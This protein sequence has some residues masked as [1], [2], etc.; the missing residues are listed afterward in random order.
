MKVMI[1]GANGFIGSAVLRRLMA[2]KTL[3]IVATARRTL[4][5]LESNASFIFVPTLNA[6]TRWREP[7]EGVD[8]VVHTAARVHIIKELAHDP[9]TAYR[10]IN[11]EGTLNLARQAA[12]AGVKRFIHISSI[13]VNGESTAPGH[14]FTA[15]SPPAA[16]DPYGISKMEADQGL[17]KISQETGME[18]V[19]I[20]PP[21]VYGPS[22]KANFLTLMV[23]VHRGFPLPLGA[24]HN[25]RSLVSLDNLVDLVN[26]CLTH[27]AAAGQIF[28]VCDG[29]D[30]STTELLKRLGLAIGTS[31]R[32]IPIPSWLLRLGA[33][34]IR[35]PDIAQRLCNSLQV[36]MSKTQERLNWSPIIDVDEGFRRATEVLR[37]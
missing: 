13:K 27:P 25:K 16:R 26:T 3:K 37:Q 17:Q 12:A 2:D 19:I 1:T 4:P 10:A 31:T 5:P 28:L 9:L 14:P 34:F 29:E 23:L 21:L 20:R 8:V 7:L 32:L 18:C 24:I 22:V 30:L 35:R 36:D 6:S 33:T 11:V 15:E